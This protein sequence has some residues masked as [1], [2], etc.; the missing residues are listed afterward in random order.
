MGWFLKNKKAEVLSPLEG[1]DQWA[2]SYHL[3]SNPIKKFSDDLVETLLPDLQGKRVLDAGCGTG[4]FCTYAEKQ[5][6]LKISGIDLSPNMIERSRENCPSGDFRCEDLS[7]AS[8]KEKEFDVII[9][10]L[11][12]GHLE[13]L[14]P[15][16]DKL[17]KALDNGGVLILT[18]FHPFLTLMQAKR[19][20]RNPFTGRHFEV[21]HYLH[22]FR[23]YFTCFINHRVSVEAW[24]E[25]LYNGKP[26][27]FGIRVKKI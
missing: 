14:S 19:T 13:K 21:R 23:D 26:V 16:L 15:V 1:Y 24:N 5:N 11:V 2:S 17:L 7:I 6:A 4:K 12:L 27:V 22:L 8:L 10:A 20:F 18:D 25:P 9:C 3:E